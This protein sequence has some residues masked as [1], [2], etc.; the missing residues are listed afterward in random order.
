M[1]RK[2]S[3]LILGS[4]LLLFASVAAVFSFDLYTVPDNLPEIPV[5][6]MPSGVKRIDMDI[7]ANSNGKALLSSPVYDPASDTY[8]VPAYSVTT[9]D[10]PDP[11]AVAYGDV[12]E[13]SQTIGGPV[14]VSV[15]GTDILKLADGTYTNAAPSQTLADAFASVD[16][17]QD[18]TLNGYPYYECSSETI[19]GILHHCASGTDFTWP[20][21]YAYVPGDATVPLSAYGFTL[22]NVVSGYN[23]LSRYGMIANDLYR[24]P[25][26]YTTQFVICIQDATSCRKVFKVAASYADPSLAETTSPDSPTL[27]NALTPSQPDFANNGLAGDYLAACAAGANCTVAGG[28]ITSN[29]VDTWNS[30]NTQ[31]INDAISDA[32]QSGATTAITDGSNTGAHQQQTGQL[33]GILSALNK[34]NNTADDIEDKM[35]EGYELTGSTDLPSDN[36]YDSSITQPVENSLSDTISSYITS[37]LPLTQFLNNSGF[38]VS[39]ADPRLSCEL[40]GSTIDFDI[41]PMESTLHWMGLIVFA[42]STISAFMIVIKR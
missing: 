26:G 36:T 22:G 39:G 23:C 3:L 18:G 34:L 12:T 27:A 7:Y 28:D 31:V 4:T 33:A 5:R 41:S 19:D 10:A 38:T 9:V 25:A 8:N 11:E 15:P 13:Q 6:T 20:Q 37:G 35:D 42:V 16:Q 2:L 32:I 40:W 30:T 24:Y 14:T 29:D 21:Y 17:E 1:K